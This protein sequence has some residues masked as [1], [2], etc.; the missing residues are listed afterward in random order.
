[1]YTSYLR[2]ICFDANMEDETS[3]PLM[4]SVKIVLIYLQGTSLICRCD[5]H[6][7]FHPFLSENF[8]RS[9]HIFC[10]NCTDATLILAAL[11]AIQ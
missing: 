9:E 6:F 8:K 10:S 3:A 5:C 1:M 7:T 4:Y 2:R 11:E